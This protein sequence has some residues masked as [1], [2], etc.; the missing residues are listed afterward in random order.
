MCAWASDG[1]CGLF[2]LLCPRAGV[3][4]HDHA[5]PAVALSFILASAA[6][7][8]SALCYAEFAARVPVSGSAYTF[9]YTSLGE[10]FAWFIGWNL[11]LEYGISAS[12]VA[13]GWANYVQRLFATSGA[14]LPKW[15]HALPLN[16]WG[17]EVSLLAAFIVLAC[18]AILAL[19]V[20]ESAR[21]NIVITVINMAVV[22]FSASPVC[23]S[24][25][26]TRRSPLA[27]WPAAVVVAGAFKV[28]PAN[29]TPFAPHGSSGVVS[30][31]G[32]VFFSF[33]G[34][35]G[36]RVNPDSSRPC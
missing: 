17:L 23:A 28:D 29:W 30:A 25:A 36:A 14:P 26:L 1:L 21:F 7:L 15:V 33:V 34:F 19:G 11:T 9:A 27:R 12:A 20:K 6:C 22:L 24:A 10:A 18:S 4:A 31:A 3:A 35:D 5:G 16:V 13:R 8:L 32:V 2:A